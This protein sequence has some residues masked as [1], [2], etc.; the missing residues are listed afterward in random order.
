MGNFQRNLERNERFDL[1][2]YNNILLKFPHILGYNAVRRS[3]NF[4]PVTMKALQPLEDPVRNEKTSLSVE[5]NHTCRRMSQASLNSGSIFII[6]DQKKKSQASLQLLKI[7]IINIL[8]PP[9]KIHVYQND[10]REP[11]L[12]KN[13]IKTIA[14]VFKP[15]LYKDF[16]RG[17]WA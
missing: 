12:Q 3:C 6:S 11:K 2:A 8:S 17:T 9:Q 5:S 7:C 10:L 1:E 16:S 4:L 13:G 15:G 14:A